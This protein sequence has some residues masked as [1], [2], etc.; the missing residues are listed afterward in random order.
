MEHARFYA[1]NEGREVFWNAEHFEAL[2]FTLS[3]VA[4]IIFAYG[5]YRRWRMW[6]AIGKPDIRWDNA[7]ERLKRLLLDGLFQI[8]IF[9]ELYPGIMHGLIFFGFCGL[10]FGTFF[11]AVEYHIT[12][13]LG[14]AFPRRKAKPRGSVIWY[15]TASKNVPNIKPQKPKKIRPCMMPG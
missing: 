12:E 11:D 7:Q 14:F 6:K 8:R 3:A 4:L 13:P 5:V 1:G 15:S 2:L 9:R 10:M